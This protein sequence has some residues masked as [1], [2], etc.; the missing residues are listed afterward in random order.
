[1]FSVDL[2]F[3]NINLSLDFF[4]NLFLF[5]NFFSGLGSILGD[6]F[7]LPGTQLLHQVSFLALSV[8]N[9]LVFDR[10]KSA[11]HLFK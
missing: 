7:V 4:N 11:T 9:E 3:F 10:F 2:G 5:F 6:L 8:I 1:L